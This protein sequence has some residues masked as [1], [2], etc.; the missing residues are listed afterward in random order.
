[1]ITLQAG[2]KAPDF[3]G[4]NQ[5][6]KSISLS[7]YKGKKVILYFYPRDNTPGCTKE[8]CD[9]ND[10]LSVLTEKG[11][12]VIGVSPDSIASHQKFIAKYD[13]NF[14]LISDPDKEILLTYGAYGDKTLY[15]KISI[16]V[17]RSTFIIGEDGV[18]LA[19]IKSVKTKEA[20]EQ[21]LRKLGLE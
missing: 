13:L 14:E 7:D 12:V 17:L 3:K 10:N 16:G 19:V 20:T 11:F 5:D 4:L 6:E 1:M 2:D 9:F 18:L 15:G 8:A 21:V